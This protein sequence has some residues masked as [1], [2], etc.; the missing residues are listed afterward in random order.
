MADPRTS[1]LVVL[2]T[3]KEMDTIQIFLKQLDLPTKQVLI[4]ANLLETSA[5]PSTAKGI[6]WSGTLEA[7]NVAFGNN[8]T[9]LTP[10]SLGTPATPAPRHHAL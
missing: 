6:N 7:Q 9:F 5:N 4:E 3:E 1:Q 8:T 10:P 2:A